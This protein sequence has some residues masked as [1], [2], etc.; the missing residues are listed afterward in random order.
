MCGIAGII[1]SDPSLLNEENLKKMAASLAHRGPDGQA[2][3]IDAGH[4]GFAHRRLCVIDISDAAAQPMHYLSRYSIVHNGEIYNYEELKAILLQKG[5]VFT[6]RSDTEVILAA[7]AEYGSRCLDYFDG[8]FA[9]AIWDRRQRQLFCARDRFGEKPFY[10]YFDESNKAFYFGSELRALYA[11]GIEKTENYSLLLRFLTLGHVSDASDR[12]ATFDA[13]IKKLPPSHTLTYSHGSAPVVQ[14][15]WDL[16]LRVHPLPAKAAKDRLN[17]L[18]L[19]SV[20]RRLRSDVPVGTS[21]SGGLDSSSIAFFIKETGAGHLK[22]FTAAFP[23]FEKD[24]S[25]IASAVASQFGFDNYQAEVGADD[26]I[27]N[28]ESVLKSQEQPFGSASVC[29]QYEVFKLASRQDVTVLLDGQGAD[30]TL[31]GY[32][33]YLNWRIKTL[34]PELT[35]Q[36]L[37]RREE[38]RLY[39]D[40][41]INKPF[42]QTYSRGIRLTKPAVGDLNDLLCFEIFYQGLEDLL[43]YADRNSMAHGREVRLPFLNHDLVSFVFSLPSRYKTGGG[44]TKLILRKLMDGR[45]PNGIVWKRRKTGFEPPQK[46]WMQHPRVIEYFHECTKALVGE[47]ILRE[48]VLSKRQVFHNAY[49]SGAAEWR[50]LVAGGLIHSNKKGV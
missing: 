19:T 47:K 33:K 50:W 24:E 1:S 32:N 28:F 14:Q 21:L 46:K 10:Y 43:R 12:S 18:L 38:R 6:T 7:Y 35:S 17:E 4:A 44:Y 48:K 5:Y 27:A 45:L 42:L 36:L 3:W 13:R 11:A 30:E 37:I 49:E 2:V 16:S 20:K 9:F 15:Y 22:S 41:Y 23:G 34:L 40:A 26:F 31:A 29:A 25:A 8:M 39:R